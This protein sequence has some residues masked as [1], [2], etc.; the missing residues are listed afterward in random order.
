[1]QCIKLLTKTRYHLPS[2]IQ[3]HVD[4][5]TPGIKLIITSKN[6]GL[7]KRSSI[8]GKSKGITP[9]G[10]PV[11]DWRAPSD[12][13]SLATCD[14]LI[15]PS[16]IKA[17]Y[18]IPPAPIFPNP[19]NAMGIYEEGDYYD[20]EDL[21]L[22]FQKYTQYIPQGT[23]PTPN[24]IDGAEAPVPVADGGG[25]ST[26]DME[27]TYPIIFPQKIILY[28]TDDYDYAAEYPVEGFGNEFLDALDGVCPPFPCHG[29]DQL[30]K[31]SPTAHIQHTA[32]LET[33]Q[34]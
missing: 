26:L 19:T 34:F 16:C 27:L 15:T 31:S 14:V 22:F 29:D 10:A 25:E 32:R 5:V 9:L 20:Q 2:H 33:T 3:E 18:Q 17:L 4:Y 23:H 28:Q 21:D 1:L 30:I 12:P 24:F 13:E 8:P 11:G 6:A 7:K